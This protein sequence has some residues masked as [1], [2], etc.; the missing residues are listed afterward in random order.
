MSVC[1]CD[2]VSVCVKGHSLKYVGVGEFLEQ[3]HLVPFPDPVHPLVDLQDHDFICGN[4]AH[5]GGGVG[6]GDMCGEECEGVR[7]GSV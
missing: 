6:R 4:V 7:K 5:L 1:M 2:C 3:F